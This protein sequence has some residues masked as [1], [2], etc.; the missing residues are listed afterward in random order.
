MQRHWTP[1]ELAEQWT[2]F[3]RER[4]LLANK[5]GPTRLGFAVLLKYFQC[6][7]RF[8]VHSHEVPSAVVAYLAQQ[9]GVA[10]EV[11]PQY[12]WNGRAIKYHRA[13]IRQHLGFREAT[14]ADGQA[15]SRWLG[16]QILATTHRLEHLREAVY[17]RC[18]N[19]QIEPP[20][21]DR[22]DRLINAAVQTFEPDFD[23]G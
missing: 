11:W 12:N 3:P 4:V 23:T 17:Q 16:E 9:V 21:P 14:S 22:L 15:L 1:E 2:L 5:S 7:A 6:E 8:P 18:R 13:Q 10:A 19:L 20:T